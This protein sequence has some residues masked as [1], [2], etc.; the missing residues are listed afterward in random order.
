VGDKIDKNEMEW[1][2]ARM[3]EERGVY[4]FFCGETCGKEITGKTQA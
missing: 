1:H 2:I 4:R 3:G